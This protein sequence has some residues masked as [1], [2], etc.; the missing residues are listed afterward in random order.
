MSEKRF[1]GVIDE[2]HWFAV[3]SI[4]NPNFIHI[5]LHDE[6]GKNTYYDFRIL[7]GDSNTIDLQPIVNEYREWL[8]SKRLPEKT[9]ES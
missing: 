3:S 6:N 9:N 7:N 5:T 2:I 8:N 1:Q 4:R